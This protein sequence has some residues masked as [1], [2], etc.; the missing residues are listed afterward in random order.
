MLAP[1]SH[2]QEAQSSG[3]L[4]VV[5]QQGKN[6]ITISGMWNRKTDRNTVFSGIGENKKKDD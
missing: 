1:S 2:L 4:P 3:W 5:V 6:I